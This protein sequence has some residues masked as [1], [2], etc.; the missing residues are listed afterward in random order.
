MPFVDLLDGEPRNL[1]FGSLALS[2]FER[3]ICG[4]VGF[5]ATIASSLHVRPPF[6]IITGLLWVGFNCE[7]PYEDVCK[8][9]DEYVKISGDT[10]D[11]R[12][13]QAIVLALNEAGIFREEAQKPVIVT[14][15]R[16]PI[17]E[18]E[19]EREPLHSVP[20]RGATDEE[21][22]ARIERLKKER[23]EWKRQMGAN[24]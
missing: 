12:I 2:R 4:G 20:P 9:L 23:R 16:N 17:P 18:P 15:L 1:Q 19:L 24:L 5:Y 3:E 11:G 13:W 14:G 6:Y 8:K 7:T 22:Q 21:Y 10:F